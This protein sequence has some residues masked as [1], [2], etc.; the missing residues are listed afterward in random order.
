MFSK[1]VFDYI[2]LYHLFQRSQEILNKKGWTC[3]LD[4]NFIE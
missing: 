3:K 2:E 1:I 4:K